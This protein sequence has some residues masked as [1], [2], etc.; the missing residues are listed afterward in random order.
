VVIDVFHVYASAG[1]VGAK[2][3]LAIQLI[4]QISARI[5]QEHLDSLHAIRA[6]VVD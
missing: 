2:G 1:L 3:T 4:E 5:A 6:G